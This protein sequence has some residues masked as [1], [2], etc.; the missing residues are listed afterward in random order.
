MWQVHNATVEAGAYPSPLNYFHFPKSVCTSV[1]EVRY[2][3]R[4]SGICWSVKNMTAGIILIEHLHHCARASITPHSTMHIVESEW[5]FVLRYVWQC[6]LWG[7]FQHL[8]LCCHPW[9]RG[10][11]VGTISVTK[12][13]C[14]SPS[15]TC[16]RWIVGVGTEHVCWLKCISVLLFLLHAIGSG[17]V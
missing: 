13:V 2:Q 5:R 11:T 17:G 15:M 9:E 14:D 10:E 12:M 6:Y 1:N 16:G 3:H 8:A 7:Q 4:V